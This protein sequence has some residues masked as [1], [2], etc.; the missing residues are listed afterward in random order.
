MLIVGA[1]IKAA[2]ALLGWSQKTLAFHADVR[3]STLSEVERSKRGMGPRTRVKLLKALDDAG[4]AFLPSEGAL[5]PGV[6][7]V[8][9]GSHV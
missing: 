1:Q 2:R 3:R 7:L 5:G 4:V 6:R 8:R 9:N